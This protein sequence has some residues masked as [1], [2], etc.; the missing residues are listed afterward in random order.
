[1]STFRIPAG[2]AAAAGLIAAIGVAG[3]PA[4]ASLTHNALTYNALTFN[5]LSSAGSAI[6][7]LNGVAV[8]AVALPE[9]AAQA[10]ADSAQPDERSAATQSGKRG[11][12]GG[13]G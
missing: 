3:T 13:A 6:D 1:M 8:E 4:R 5:A 12:G 11:G 9:A 2:I 7:D 10:P